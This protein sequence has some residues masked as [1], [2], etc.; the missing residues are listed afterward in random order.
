MLPLVKIFESHSIDSD[1]VNVAHIKIVL[2]GTKVFKNCVS[3]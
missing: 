1:Q 2:N 3:V